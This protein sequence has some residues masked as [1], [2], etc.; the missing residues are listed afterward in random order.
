M[1]LMKILARLLPIDTLF[2]L[3]RKGCLMQHALLADNIVPQCFLGK[4]FFFFSS[5]FLSIS[6]AIQNG[7]CMP[8][9]QLGFLFAQRTFTVPF[10]GL[11]FLILSPCRNTLCGEEGKHAQRRHQRARGTSCLQHFW[12]RAALALRQAQLFLPSFPSRGGISQFSLSWLPRAWKTRALRCHQL[13]TIPIQRFQNTCGAD[14]HLK[15][16]EK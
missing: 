12:P 13:H 10:S 1:T 4:H 6:I 15:R 11:N 7:N 14:S 9:V 2:H 3:N 8:R 5:L 16:L